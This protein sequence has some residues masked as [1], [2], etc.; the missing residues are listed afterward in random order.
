[1]TFGETT[2]R[3]L[4]GLIIAICAASWLTLGG[5]LLFDGP[6]ALVVAAVFA[7]ALS[8]E[9]VIWGGAVLLGWTAFANRARVWKR[10]T[11]QAV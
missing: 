4:A 7:A 5:A 11:G 8:T 9:A 3:V 1:M 10:L 2:R 6:R